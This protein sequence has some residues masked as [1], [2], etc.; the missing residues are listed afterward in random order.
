MHHKSLSLDIQGLIFQSFHQHLFPYM[1]AFLRLDALT[2]KTD[3]NLCPPRVDIQMRK[4]RCLR[5]WVS[6]ILSVKS[7]LGKAQTES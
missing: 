7:V 2:L 4:V 5:R 1:S 6:E 3:T